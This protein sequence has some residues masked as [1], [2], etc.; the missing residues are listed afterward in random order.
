M[1]RLAGIA[2]IV[3]SMAVSLFFIDRNITDWSSEH[4][5]RQNLEASFTLANT[6]W[7]RPNVVFPNEK[8]QSLGNYREPLPVFFL[9]L[10][11]LAHPVL[12]KVRTV[13][14]MDQGDNLISL[15]RHHLV[16]ASLLMLGAALLVRSIGGTGIVGTGGA[17]VAIGLATAD[18]LV[19]PSVIDRFYT[20]IQAATILLWLSYAL[21]L[22]VKT[23]RWR[24]FALAGLL[25]GALALT[26][27]V[28]FYVG[29]VIPPVMLAVCLLPPTRWSLRSGAMNYA[30]M[31]LAMF[32]VVAPWMLN[33]Y[34]K[35][36]H[37]TI[38]QR[39]G[40]I[41]MIRAYNNQM[42]AEEAQGAFYA[43][44]PVPL[45]NLIG[46]TLGFSRDDL[47]KGGRLQRLNI[48][49]NQAFVKE[50]WAAEI[51]GRPE[52]ALTFYTAGR[53]E[54]VKLQR[55]LKAD[56]VESSREQVDMLL[57]AKAVSMIL[58]DPINH[59]RMTPLFF[60][61][62][63]WTR[64]PSNPPQFLVYVLMVSGFFVAM[65]AGLILRRPLILACTL[66]TAGATFFFALFTQFHPRFSDILIPV[67][68]ASAVAAC[69]F[70][71]Q[72]LV[73]QMARRNPWLAR[74]DGQ[75]Q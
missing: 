29:I 62:G 48:H 74:F 31:A 9:A 56:G 61:R 2:A 8:E 57:R 75:N 55:E 73:S 42:T 7:P 60:W 12:S 72:G 54:G 66:P 26:K 30:T 23:K 70:V 32:V 35:N 33:N 37:L 21:V 68:E 14:E 64:G 41:L 18:F 10:N 19:R 50:D 67:M 47:S 24:W 45:K 38:S 59:L 34:A 28:F 39:G 52:D 25:T 53:A 69:V 15:K 4:D 17:I 20:E 22:A 43:W 65:L 36:G 16:W 27:S 5:A 63:L 49:G 71:L 11:I 3:I 13:D 44:A 58:T 40:V 46:S 1:S 6:L 51:A